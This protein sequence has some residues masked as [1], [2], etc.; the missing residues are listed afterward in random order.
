MYLA[1]PINKIFPPKMVV[2][3]ANAEIQIAA[4]QSILIQRGLYMAA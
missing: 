2:S 4:A 1:A 3:E